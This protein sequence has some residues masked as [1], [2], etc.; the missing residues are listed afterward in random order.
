MVVRSLDMKKDAFS[1]P[2]DGEELLGPE[3]PYLNDIGAI[4]YLASGTRPDI[5]FAVNLLARALLLL[6]SIGQ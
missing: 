1:P 4:M 2:D 6:N 3:V 5:A